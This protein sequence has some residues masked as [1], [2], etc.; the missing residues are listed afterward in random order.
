MVALNF[1]M[2]TKSNYTAWSMRMSAVMQAH[3][4]WE[5]VESKDPKAKIKEKKDRIA[6]AAIYQAIPED[7]L[8]YVADKKTTQ[9]TWEAIKL[10][11]LGAERVHNA[12][13]Q[14]MKTEFAQEFADERDRN[15]GR[16]CV[17]AKWFGP[18]ETIEE[19]YIMKKL[20]RAVPTRFLQ[21]TSAIE[22]FGKIEEMSLEEVVGSLKA[23]GERTQ[24]PTEKASRNSC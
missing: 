21:I 14:T 5:A 10:L 8:L 16:L 18:G 23:H 3:E 1:S 15:H 19:G 11:C 12:G 20:L 13:V 9:K 7:I 2:L 17:A 6:L 24:G 4:I 22:Q